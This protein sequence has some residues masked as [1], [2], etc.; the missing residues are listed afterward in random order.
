MKKKTESRLIKNIDQA[1]ITFPV[2]LE[3]RQRQELIDGIFK[4]IKKLENPEIDRLLNHYED[5]IQNYDLKDLLYGNIEV[6]NASRLDTKTAAIMSCLLAMIAFSSELLDNEGR[7]I[8]LIDIP[9]DNIAVSAIEYIRS[10][11]VLDDLLEYLLYSIISIVGGEY[12]MAF[13][14]KIASENFSNEDILHLENDGELN[15]H[16]DLMAWF[17][18]MR[19]FL[20]SVYFYFND[21]NHN[22]KKPL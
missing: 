18:V 8:P 11:I 9:E 13:Q 10:S 16:I 20:E 19:L 22:I 12:Y 17:A 2:L 3:K 14:Q 4:L 21:E 6:L 15:E 1:Q 5:F 7:M